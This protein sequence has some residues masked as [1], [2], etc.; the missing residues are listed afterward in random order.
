M[1]ALV[2]GV[3][4]RVFYMPRPRGAGRKPEMGWWRLPS[5]DPSERIRPLSERSLRWGCDI[6]QR[7]ATLPRF[8]SLPGSVYT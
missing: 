1:N 3:F 6:L 2:K 4:Y 7:I 8:V 5:T